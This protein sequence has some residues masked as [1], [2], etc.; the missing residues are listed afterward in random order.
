MRWNTFMKERGLPF[1]RY[2]A[3]SETIET[4]PKMKKKLARDSM[5]ERCKLAK[6]QN[7][8]EPII[9]KILKCT[10]DIA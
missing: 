4:M 8:L 2:F 9:S 7:K 10:K 1:N 3:K 6:K 5:Q